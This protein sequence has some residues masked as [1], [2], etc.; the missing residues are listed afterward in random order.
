MH[1]TLKVLTCIPRDSPQDTR[2]AG[3]GSASPGVMHLH[4]G[5][6]L[7]FNIH[8]NNQILQIP[9]VDPRNLVQPQF[10]QQRVL[11][12][13]MRKSLGDTQESGAQDKSAEDIHE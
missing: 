8:R 10:L 1:Y 13:L 9:F 4:H 12:I 11:H 5:K 6:V 3:Q 7:I 2:K